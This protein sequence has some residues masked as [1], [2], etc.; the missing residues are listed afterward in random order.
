MVVK[1]GLVLTVKDLVRKSPA[2]PCSDQRFRTKIRKLDLSAQTQEELPK[3]NISESTADSHTIEVGAGLPSVHRDRAAM[4]RGELQRRPTFAGRFK[5]VG[6]V[7]CLFIHL[8][9]IQP[10]RNSLG[11]VK[12]PCM[13][14]SFR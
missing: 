9:R 4:K 7:G 13:Q 11:M 3:I 12:T 6:S 14:I 5:Q 2:Q 10:I 8:T 1:E